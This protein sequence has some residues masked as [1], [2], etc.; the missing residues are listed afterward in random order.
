MKLTPGLTTDPK[1]KG[2]TGVELEPGDEGVIEGKVP[3][4]KPKPKKEKA[5]RYTLEDF[6]RTW[7]TSRS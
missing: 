7:Q 6:P 3:L 5:T 1:A 4:P 2:W